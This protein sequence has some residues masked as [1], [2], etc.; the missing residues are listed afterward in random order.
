MIYV[1]TLYNNQVNSLN[2]V[3]KSVLIIVYDPFKT[4]TNIFFNK[5]FKLLT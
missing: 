4:M 2:S 1:L 3:L 5:S